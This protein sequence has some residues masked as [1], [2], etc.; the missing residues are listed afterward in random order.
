MKTQ[1]EF[2]ERMFFRMAFFRVKVRSIA[3]VALGSALVL[4]RAITQVFNPKV[5]LE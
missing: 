1:S 2:A 3:K 4:L 5:T